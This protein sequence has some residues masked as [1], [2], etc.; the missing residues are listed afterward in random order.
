MS[1]ES[2]QV[3]ALQEMLLLK[4][5]AMF[6]I[7]NLYGIFYYFKTF[8]PELFHLRRGESMIFAAPIIVL[9]LKLLTHAKKSQVLGG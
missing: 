4:L 6:H 5:D 1:A 8:L 9:N 3:S 2:L 7:L